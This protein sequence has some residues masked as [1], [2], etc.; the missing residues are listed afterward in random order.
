MKTPET[1]SVLR[2]IRGR[3]PAYQI[4]ILTAH[5]KDMERAA[6]E[7][8]NRAGAWRH[9]CAAYMGVSALSGAIVSKHERAFAT[10]ELSKTLSHS[11]RRTPYESFA[12]AERLDRAPPQ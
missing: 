6:I 12:K 4:R 11:G 7:G 8:A 2:M 3:S 9:A 1:K 5:S 10:A